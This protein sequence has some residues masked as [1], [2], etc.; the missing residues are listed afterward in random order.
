[1][2]LV[3]VLTHIWRDLMAPNDRRLRA[4]ALDRLIR[5]SASAGGDGGSGDLRYCIVNEPNNSSPLVQRDTGAAD[6]PPP[7]PKSGPVSVSCRHR[8]HAA[9]YYVQAL[10]ADS[11]VDRRMYARLG[12]DACRQACEEM[13]REGRRP[14]AATYDVSELA[15]LADDPGAAYAAACEVV[16]A[17]GISDKLRADAAVIMELAFVRLHLPL[18]RIAYA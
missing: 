13:R 4:V 17:S 8:F 6:L 18:P 14:Y 16:S 7:R 1:M 5:R 2:G 3:A 10:S 11:D 12:L 15:L 9:C